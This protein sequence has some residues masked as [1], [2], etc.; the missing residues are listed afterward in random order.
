MLD[1]LKLSLDEAA[2]DVNKNEDADEKV[3]DCFTRITLKTSQTISRL[4]QLHSNTPERRAQSALRNQI[5][6]PKSKLR[7][8]STDDVNERAWEPLAPLTTK[9]TVA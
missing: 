3:I 9:N 5:S 6:D 2:L 7:I 4:K 1:S 8:L